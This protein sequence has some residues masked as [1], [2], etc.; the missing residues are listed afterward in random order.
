K[1]TKNL[2]RDKTAFSTTVPEGITNSDIFK[3]LVEKK[4]EINSP[5]TGWFSR[6]SLHSFKHTLIDVSIIFFLLSLAGSSISSVLGLKAGSDKALRMLGE[7]TGVKFDDVAGIDEAKTELQE[8]VEFLKN[9][10]KFRK[11]GA[12]IPKG[13]LLTGPPGT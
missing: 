13:V 2:S 4:V 1:A 8:V 12:K 5:A 7:K 9:P 6:N 11:L 3:E 10:Q